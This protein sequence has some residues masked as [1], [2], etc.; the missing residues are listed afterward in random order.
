MHNVWSLFPL[1]F[2][3]NNTMNPAEVQIVITVNAKDAGCKL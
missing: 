1:T 3:H 2:L